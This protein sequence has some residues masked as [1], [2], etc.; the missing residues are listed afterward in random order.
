MTFLLFLIPA[1]IIPDLDF[2][3]ML[4]PLSGKL[5]PQIFARLLS[6]CQSGLIQMSL[7]QRPQILRYLTEITSFYFLWSIYHNQKISLLDTLFSVFPQYHVNSMIAGMLC[8]P[9]L[10]TVPLFFER[11]RKREQ[12]SVGGRG[13]RERNISRRHAQQRA[14]G[15]APSYYSEIRT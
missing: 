9:V 14:Q 2:F 7:S 13:G 6:F 12:V 11:E 4:F 10:F 8:L 5:W 1:K 3:Y 15:G